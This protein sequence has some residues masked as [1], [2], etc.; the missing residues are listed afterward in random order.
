MDATPATYFS[1]A[2]M[3]IC[4]RKVAR[5][6]LTDKEAA[7]DYFDMHAESLTEVERAEFEQAVV[8]AAVQLAEAS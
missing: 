6:R 3:Q 1:Y 7:A 5:L 4:A 2:V 8:K